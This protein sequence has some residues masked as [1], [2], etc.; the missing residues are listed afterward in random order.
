[1]KYKLSDN[2]IVTKFDDNEALLTFKNKTQTAVLNSTS[3]MILNLI[4]SKEF[5]DAQNQFIKEF[6]T[7]DITE[8]EIK[9]LMSDFND[10]YE[11][12][13]LNNII[14]KES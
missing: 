3:L 9:E 1:M 2:A 11:L 8:N 12:F 14:E 7:D 4:V 5:K 10:I 6:S 13:L